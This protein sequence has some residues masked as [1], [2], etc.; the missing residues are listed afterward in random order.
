MINEFI[1]SLKLN[2]SK[3]IREFVD[4]KNIFINVHFIQKK[5]DFLY[6]DLR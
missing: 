2:N 6:E 4:K 3:I 1:D 5:V